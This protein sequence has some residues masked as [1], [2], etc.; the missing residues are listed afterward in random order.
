MNKVMIIGNVTRDPELRRTQSGTSVCTFGIA[1]SRRLTQEQKQSGAQGAD[2]F[3]VVAW[4]G[5]AEACG[6][7]LSKGKKAAVYGRLQT[8]SYEA[9]RSALTERSE[10]RCDR[11][12]QQ[13]NK[14][15]VTEIVAEE[16]EFLFP[17][18][19]SAFA[20]Y[21]QAELEPIGSDEPLPF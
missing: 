6:K 14:R 20:P 19:E 18:E 17:R 3:T 13:I 2:F 4:K 5:T 12:S 9:K 10:E 7:Y 11:S 8:R 16:V 15:F 21:S 1:V